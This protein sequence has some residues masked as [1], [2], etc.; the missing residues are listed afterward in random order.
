MPMR[1]IKV[2]TEDCGACK[3]LERNLKAA[4]I[5]YSDATEDEIAKYNVCAVPTLLLVDG[6]LVIK[7]HIGILTPEQLKEFTR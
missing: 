5:E 3:V 4:G 6:D 2:S 7:K 1:L